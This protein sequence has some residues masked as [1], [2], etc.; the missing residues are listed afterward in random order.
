MSVNI[1]RVF[2]CPRSSSL[3]QQHHQGGREMVTERER[4]GEEETYSIVSYSALATTASFRCQKQRCTQSIKLSG[5][6]EMR[7][8]HNWIRKEVS[9][10][11]G[12]DFPRKKGK[13][14]CESNVKQRRG[15]SPGMPGGVFRYLPLKC[16]ITTSHFSVDSI[17]QQKVIHRV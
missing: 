9:H 14:W 4:E 16:C 2:S 7:N 8:Y 6:S 15:D 5:R 13:G 10:F 12:D 11:K 1:K 3:Q 17:L